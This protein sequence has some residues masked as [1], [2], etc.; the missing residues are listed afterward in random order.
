VGLPCDSPAGSP[1]QVPSPERRPPYPGPSKFVNRAAY[2]L[3]PPGKSTFRPI[4]P[5]QR[6]AEAPRSLAARS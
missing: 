3:F 5:V 4:R 6:S 1:C 2:P